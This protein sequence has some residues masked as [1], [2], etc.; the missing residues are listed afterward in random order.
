MKHWIEFS[1]ALAI[2]LI[3]GLDQIFGLSILCREDIFFIWKT[4]FF[5]LVHKKII[6]QIIPLPEVKLNIEN[7]TDLYSLIA[8]SGSRFL[9]QI[10]LES[11]M[12]SNHGTYIGW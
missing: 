7:F 4:Y 9:F 5:A 12:G 6:I 10:M 2:T 11:W 3:L 1:S 8:W